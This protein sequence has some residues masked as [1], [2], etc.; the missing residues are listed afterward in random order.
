MR[1][2]SRRYWQFLE[3]WFSVIRGKPLGHFLKNNQIL[4]NILFSFIILKTLPS[5]WPII[6]YYR[7]CV[8]T[9]QGFLIRYQQLL[10]E[11]IR[12]ALNQQ[13]ILTEGHNILYPV[14]LALSS[15]SWF[16][17][18][19]S[20][21]LS[22][23]SSNSFWDLFFLNRCYY[24]YCNFLDF[25]MHFYYP[26]SQRSLTVT[27]FPKTSFGKVTKCFSARCYFS[28]SISVF[29]PGE[30]NLTVMSISEF[31]KI[32]NTFLFI[33][34]TIGSFLGFGHNLHLLPSCPTS[35]L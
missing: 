27:V 34:F 22:I 19:H 5:S 32:Y 26:S 8:S 6:Q 2:S 30:R 24:L 12:F 17:W 10:Q 33:F 13:S 20:N 7:I 28:N 11:D 18:F 23:S 3:N 15:R 14:S 35:H 16:L 29:S 25:H 21:S 4:H 31:L 9:I 1:C